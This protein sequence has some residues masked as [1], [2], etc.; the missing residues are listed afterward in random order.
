MVGPPEIVGRIPSRYAV[1]QDVPQWTPQ[2]N[3]LL[4]LG[5][6]PSPLEFDWNSV[7]DNELTTVAGRQRLGQRLKAAVGRDCDLRIYHGNEISV[8]QRGQYGEIQISPGIQPVGPTGSENIDFF[9]QDAS[10]RMQ[11]GLFGVVSQISPSG[12]DNFEDLAL[13][14]PSDDSQH[15]LV[16]AFRNGDEIYVYRRLYHSGVR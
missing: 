2:L 4:V 10:V 15:L 1:T 16:V 9:L 3:R 6:E 8:M 7:T 5:S 11:G 14:D 12:G 13:L